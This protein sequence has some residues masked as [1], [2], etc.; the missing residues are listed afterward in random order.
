MGDGMARPNWR[1]FLICLSAMVITALALVPA[2][3][4]LQ[5]HQRSAMDGKELPCVT[6]AR[7]T[8]V[9]M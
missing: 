6:A 7:A 5:A 4:A 3:S 8:N 9:P 2:L 1:F